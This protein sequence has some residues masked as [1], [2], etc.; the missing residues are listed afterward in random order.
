MRLIFIV[1]LASYV[2]L[3]YFFILLL[4]DQPSNPKGGAITFGRRYTVPNFSQQGFLGFTCPA[5]AH[6]G[7]CL[8]I[9][10]P[11]CCKLIVTINIS[12]TWLT[13][14]PMRQPLS[15]FGCVV[16]AKFRFKF[17]VLPSYFSVK[18]INHFKP[19]YIE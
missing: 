13:N 14:A 10:Y 3:F 16:K 17:K 7:R 1:S 2:L 19:S 5:L 11:L 9:S 6:V 15:V 4:I 12:W 8:C 18:F